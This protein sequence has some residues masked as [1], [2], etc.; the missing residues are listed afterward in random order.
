MLALCFMLT[1]S[2]EALHLAVSFYVKSAPATFR[3]IFTIDTTNARG[4]RE[5]TDMKSKTNMSHSRLRLAV[6]VIAA[7][8]GSIAITGCNT[9]HGLGRDVERTGEKIERAAN[10]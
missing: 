8:L 6:L 5:T 10:K 4:G 3:N 7:A 1:P 9:M 2:R